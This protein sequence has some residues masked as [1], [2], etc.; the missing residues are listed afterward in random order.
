MKRSAASTIPRC[1]LLLLLAVLGHSSVYSEQ[2]RGAIR[3]PLFGLEY[4]DVVCQTLGPVIFWSASSRVHP[5]SHRPEHR[6][7]GRS[8]IGRPLYG[9]RKEEASF[10]DIRLNALTLCLLE[11]LG[12]RHAVVGALS[13]LKANNP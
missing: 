10:A 8:L 1:Q 13:A 2:Y 11:S 7:M 9:S 6:A 4:P 12:V 5:T 3:G